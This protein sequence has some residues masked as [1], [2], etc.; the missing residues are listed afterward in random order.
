VAA[1]HHN[2]YPLYTTGLVSPRVGPKF[3]TAMWDHSLRIW[4]FCN[5]AFHA[6]K[7]ARVKHY[8]LE[9]IEREKTRLRYRHTELKT[10]SL[11]TETF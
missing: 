3:I 7:N 2:A 6:D 4:Q 10:L 5:D 11:P 1:I 8:K 9:E